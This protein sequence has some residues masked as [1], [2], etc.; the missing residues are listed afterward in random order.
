MAPT[1]P[2][3]V[4]REAGARDADAISDFLWV[5]WNEAGTDAPG[6]AGATEQVIAE[7]AE[8]EA[9]RN[10]LGGPSPVLA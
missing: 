9:I 3:I 2:G 7:I 5:L 6:L 8:P 4:T 1:G 10:R